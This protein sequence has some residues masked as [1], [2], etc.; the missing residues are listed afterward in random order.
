MSAKQGATCSRL[1]NNFRSLSLFTGYGGLRFRKDWTCTAYYEIQ[2]AI[3]GHLSFTKF[4]VN[5][6]FIA[7][8]RILNRFKSRSRT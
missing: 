7:Q 8:S 3:Q 2:Y 6:L 4:A 1:H 5:Q